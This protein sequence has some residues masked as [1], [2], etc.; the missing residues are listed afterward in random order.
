MYIK[1][2]KRKCKERD[3]NMYCIVMKKNRNVKQ[4]DRNVAHREIY[5]YI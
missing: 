2:V 5:Q 1:R 3:K 4:R